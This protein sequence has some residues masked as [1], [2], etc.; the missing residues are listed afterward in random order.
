MTLIEDI[1]NSN[2][3]YANSNIVKNYNKIKSKFENR[4]FSN[5]SSN[6]SD[7]SDNSDNRIIITIKI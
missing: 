1:I 4:I 2:Q 3:K 5:N 7:Q 6:K